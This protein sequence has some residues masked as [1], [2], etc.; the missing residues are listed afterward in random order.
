MKKV[1][2]TVTLSLAATPVFAGNLIDRWGEPVKDRWSACVQVDY[3]NPLEECGD[4]MPLTENVIAQD[5]ESNYLQTPKILTAIT[6]DARQKGIKDSGLNK[7][8]I[9]LAPNPLKPE[10]EK[11]SQAPELS[12]EDSQSPAFKFVQTELFFE[13]NEFTVDEDHALKIHEMIQSS[14]EV[15]IDYLVVQG[16]S[17]VSGYT[18][19]NQ[20]LSELRVREVLDFIGSKIEAKM[21][22]VSQALGETQYFNTQDGAQ[23][24]RVQVYIT[25]REHQ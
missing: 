9:N 2:S 16:Y 22:I 14:K 21:G 7:P 10:A 12:T 24:R 20:T 13:P 11:P 5:S 15:E 1:L 23:N 19:W 17:D 25:G 4:A 8:L 18:G 3:A 6:Q